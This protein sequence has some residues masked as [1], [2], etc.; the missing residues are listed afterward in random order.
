[1]GRGY[2]LIKSQVNGIR[3]VGFFGAKRHDSKC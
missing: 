2:R 3:G 1:M